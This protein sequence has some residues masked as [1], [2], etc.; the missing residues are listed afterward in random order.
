MSLAVPERADHV[1]GQEVGPDKR[2][3]DYRS[4]AVLS[5]TSTT[6]PDGG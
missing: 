1:K 4:G 6:T 2:T 5:L 3:V